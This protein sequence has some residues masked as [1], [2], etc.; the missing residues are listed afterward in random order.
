MARKRKKSKA[1]KK[2]RKDESPAETRSA[3]DEKA[4]ESEATSDATA[5]DEPAEASKKAKKTKKAKK[6][7][8]SSKTKG[9][10]K[11]EKSSDEPAGGSSEKESAGPE[12][13]T[14]RKTSPEDEVGDDERVDAL[15]EIE[16]DLD[17]PDARGELIAA[18]AGLAAR[19]DDEAVEGA[20]ATGE[21]GDEIAGAEAAA[22]G[23]EDDAGPDAD[24]RDRDTGVQGDADPEAA[25]GAEA[26][27]TAE[28]PEREA[29][30]IGPDALLALSQFRA[31]GVATVPGERVL[32]LGDATSAEERDRLLAAALAHVEMQDAIY[33]V[34]LESGTTRRWKAVIASVL[35]VMALFL[36]GLPPS[37]LVPEPPAQMTAG[38]RLRGV[39]VALLLQA[40]QIEA[41]RVR[42]DRLPRSLAEVPVALP[43]IR[44]V[45]SNERLFQLIGYTPDGE[46]VVYDS[47]S[48]D[49]TFDALAESWI[50]PRA[51]S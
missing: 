37:F 15:I 5:D 45:R 14:E 26:D 28:K 21:T 18:V 40:Q 13:D 39:R 38:E 3:A 50:A 11:S 25:E 47:A 33:R 35:F 23:S 27:R 6:R 41:H 7:T 16:E 30:L 31:E 44:Y 4:A 2:R 51:D 8:T 10:R 34:P 24:G 43:G 46:A 32:D 48:P 42:H 1:G 22:G 36:V 17:D 20:A 9:G 19:T 49:P 29:P 12:K